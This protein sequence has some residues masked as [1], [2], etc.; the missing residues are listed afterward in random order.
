MTMASQ[1]HDIIII[2][3]GPAGYTAALYTARALL[4]PLIFAG[5]EPG[6][7]L[8]TTTDVENFPGFPDGIQGTDLMQR[9]RS[10]AERFGAQILDKAVTAVDF[11]THPYTITSDSETYQTHSVIIASG[12]SANWLGLPSE[13]AYRGKGVSSCATCDAFFFRGKN[14]FVVGGGNVALEDA[15]FLTNFAQHVTLIHRRDTF[16]GEKI[17]HDRVLNHDSI[18]VIWNTEL[19]E[20]LGDG[21][22]VTGVRVRNNQTNQETEH[23]TDGVFI[24]IGHTPNTALFAGQLELDPKGYLV[25]TEEVK[26]ARPGIFVAGDVADHRYQQAITAAGSG[27]KAALETEAFLKEQT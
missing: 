26:T 8:T 1:T 13:Q 6:G 7:Q 18:T 21:T 22:K 19:T 25:T 5:L 11:T 15:L 4:K 17:L 14:V 2:G 16:R 23:A 27:C 10:Q 24:F 9:M 20:V 12:S 3:S